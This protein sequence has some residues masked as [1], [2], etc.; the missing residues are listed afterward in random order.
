MRLGASVQRIVLLALGLAGL[1]L[2]PAVPAGA[3]VGADA[4]ISASAAP[5]PV[6]VGKTLVYSI[7]VTNQGI[8]AADD[9]TV[10]DVLATA[11]D[12]A[13][14]STTVGSCSG[15]TTLVCQL[16]SMAPGETATITISVTPNTSGTIVN[17][18]TVSANLDADPTDNA[19]ITQVTVDPATPGDGDGGGG[20]GGGGGARG[21]TISGTGQADVLRG[22][23]GR[24]VICAGGGDDRIVGLGG[25]DMLRG[26]AGNDRLVGG[27]SNDRLFGQGG[28]DVLRGSGGSDRLVGGASQ[29]RFSGGGGRDRCRARGGEPSRGCE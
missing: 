15:S 7:S 16:G 6:E 4:A 5:S 24:D 27:S 10:V 19:S 8:G 20:G 17:T 22:T 21:C 13:S 18:A 23:A 11:V 3:E 1:V 28:Q 12:L 29:D 9:T 2:L 14:V 25:R 26:G